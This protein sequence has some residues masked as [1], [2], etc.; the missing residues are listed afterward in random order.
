MRSLSCSLGLFQKT[1]LEWCL[2]IQLFAQQ[3]NQHRPLQ[4]IIVGT[5]N[6]S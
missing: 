2:A 4:T 5:V 1:L 3:M 6:N